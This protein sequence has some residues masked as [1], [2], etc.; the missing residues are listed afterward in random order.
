[1]AN[2]RRSAQRS[3]TLAAEQRCC[4]DPEPEQYIPI[5]Q[6]PLNLI[7]PL[8]PQEID[9]ATAAAITPAARLALALVAVHAARP[10]PSVSSTSTTSISATGN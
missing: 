10:S 5:G 4:N 3:P 1:M 2:S 6:R 8:L 9:R 7:Q